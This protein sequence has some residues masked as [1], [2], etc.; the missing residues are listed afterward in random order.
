MRQA[1][2]V[3]QLDHLAL[4]TGSVS[5]A[6][7]DRAAETLDSLAAVAEVVAVMDWLEPA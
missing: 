6:M 7:R 5:R 2:E 1:A 4:L 3:G